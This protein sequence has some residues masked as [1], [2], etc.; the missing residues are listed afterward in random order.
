MGSSAPALRSGRR[1]S[2][3]ASPA[4][5]TMPA[6]RQIQIQADQ[7]KVRPSR[8]GNTMATS[9]AVSTP[10]ASHR[11]RTPPHDPALGHQPCTQGDQHD[12][13]RHGDHKD[14]VP[15][16]P[17]E[18]RGDQHAA[19]RQPTRLGDPG[20]QAEHAED[21]APLASAEHAV[22]DAHHLRGDRGGG[23]PLSRAR[24]DQHL[25]VV[26]EAGPQ[27]GHG[28]G[29]H[30]AQEDPLAAQEIADPG[31]CDQRRGEGEQVGGRDPLQ[32]GGIGSQILLDGGQR[33]VHDRDVQQVQH[34]GDDQYDHRRPP[35][36][37]RHVGAG[38]VG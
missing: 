21:R 9:P 35:A 12:G 38:P 30:R 32:V 23:Q 6:I 28:E 27:A 24:D 22:E 14:H 18:I 5:A 16:Q 26:R 4:T 34:E 1:F 13:D 19:E 3:T 10:A 31:E 25:H 15:A 20:D 2:M 8:S 11:G 37:V 7:P 17:A 36:W 29:G 33:D